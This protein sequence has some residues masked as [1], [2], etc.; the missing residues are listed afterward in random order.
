MEKYFLDAGTT[1]SKIIGVAE[2]SDNE[3]FELSNFLV[4]MQNNK[5]YY[6]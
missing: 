5:N 1:Y 2:T 4:K 3:N 6:I